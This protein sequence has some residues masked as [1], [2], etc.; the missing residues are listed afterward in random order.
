M[1]NDVGVRLFDLVQQHDL[2]GPA[3][4]GFRELPTFLVTHVTRGRSDQPGDGMPFHVLRHVDTH[5][6]TP[7]VEEKLAQGPGQFGLAHPRGAEKKKGADGPVSV[8]QAGAVPPDGVGH[9]DD[10]FILTHHLLVQAGFHLDQLLDLA[11]DQAAHR[12]ARPLRDDLG[13]VLLVHFLFEHPAFP[14]EF[15]E[16][17]VLL[18]E[19]SVEFQL[20]AVLDAGH[21]LVIAGALRPVRFDFQLFGLFLDFLDRLYQL[22]LGEPVGPQDAALRCKVGQPAFHGLEAFLPVALAL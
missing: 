10:R 2:V 17:L 8:T 21:P 11:L 14:L 3:P 5:H 18:L 15:G 20:L 16:G 19:T 7:V 4:H 22:L 6:G 9:G 12:D 1:L 13:D